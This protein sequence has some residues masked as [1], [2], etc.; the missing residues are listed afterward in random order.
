M[1][2]PID[3]YTQIA[4]L[5]IKGIGQGFLTALGESFLALMYRAIDECP[6]AVLL[7]EIED[8]QVLGFV[9]GAVG[10]K[11]IYKQMLRYAPQLA[12][13]LAHIL[14]RR[15]KIWDISKILWRSTFMKRKNMSL[16]NLKLPPFELLSIAVAPEAR[17]YG[18]GRKLYERLEEFSFV[19]DTS[20]FYIIVGSQLSGAHQFYTQMGAVHFAEIFMRGTDKSTVYISQLPERS[21]VVREI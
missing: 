17:R 10:R 5:H 15:K 19:R 16:Q 20:G 2:E 12:L 8:G 13:A 9:A 14:L 18:L 3:L 6:V 7:T 4:R 11:P 1:A 21:E